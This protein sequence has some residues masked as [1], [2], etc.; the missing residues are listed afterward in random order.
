M[1]AFGHPFRLRRNRMYARV[2]LPLAAMLLLTAGPVATGGDK[3]EPPQQQPAWPVSVRLIAKKTTYT[4]DRQ[5]MTAEQY[6]EANKQGKLRPPAVELPLGITRTRNE[7]IATTVAGAGPRLTL[8][9]RG[10]GGIEKRTIARRRQAT[11]CIILKP[12]QTHS[13]PITHL[14]GYSDSTTENQ[15]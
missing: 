15:L 5:G 2:L 4:L 9:L 3:K 1:P 13:V 10:Q 7:R 11:V 14:A 12:G 8:E 6:R